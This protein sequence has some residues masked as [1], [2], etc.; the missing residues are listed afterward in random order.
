M[1]LCAGGVLFIRFG[2]RVYRASIKIDRYLRILL[3][4]CWAGKHPISIPVSEL[5]SRQS[6][7]Q[8][9]SPMSACPTSLVSSL[10]VYALG[11]IKDW[12]LKRLVQDP[13]LDELQVNE[14][15][16]GGCLR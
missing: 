5:P 6:G 2:W 11:F 16:H 8:S 14:K 9:V 12:V 7:S 4:I 3:R 1:E 15:N 13:R 10:V